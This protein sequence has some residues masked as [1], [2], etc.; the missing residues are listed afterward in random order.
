MKT[1][2]PSRQFLSPRSAFMRGRS[3]AGSTFELPPTRHLAH[4]AVTQEAT[5]ELPIT[6]GVAAAIAGFSST[7]PLGGAAARSGEFAEE[8]CNYVGVVWQN[9][10]VTPAAISEL[11]RAI[12][13][14]LDEESSDE[15]GVGAAAVLLTHVLEDFSR[16]TSGPLFVSL[17][18]GWSFPVITMSL[19]GPHEAEPYIRSAD[20]LVAELDRDLAD[21]LVRE[22]R[23]HASCHHGVRAVAILDLVRR[24]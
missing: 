11:C 21:P 9:A 17:V 4:T 6:V 20:E 5:R 23:V 19:R 18:W 12:V 14:R 16:H 2:P 22:H 3:P 13:A 15:S 7:E 10:V 8:R 1:P 24:I